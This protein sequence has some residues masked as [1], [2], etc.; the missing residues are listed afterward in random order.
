MPTGCLASCPPPE[1]YSDLPVISHGSRSR[2]ELGEHMLTR[3]WLPFC[4]LLFWKYFTSD[5][6]CLWY[7]TKGCVQR[8]KKQQENYSGSG[9]S[10]AVQKAGERMC[11]EGSSNIQRWKGAGN[12]I[13]LH[14]RQNQRT[15]RRLDLQIEKKAARGL[16]AAATWRVTEKRTASEWQPRA[17]W[18][19][20]I[21][22]TSPPALSTMRHS[23]KYLCVGWCDLIP[24]VSVYVSVYVSRMGLIHRRERVRGR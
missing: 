15:K 14:W 1:A 24:C 2:E 13:E 23:R 10:S 6:L 21:T 11:G 20:H 18:G 12:R 7:L 9:W 22:D 5:S 8:K 16:G 17:P 3:M 19:K 4:T